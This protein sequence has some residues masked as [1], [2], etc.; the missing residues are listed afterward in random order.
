MSDPTAPERHQRH[1]AH[2]TSQDKRLDELETES[3]VNR[4]WRVG[5]GDVHH[6][7]ESRIY[8]LE[9]ESVL[10]SD[11]DMIAAKV[12]KAYQSTVK[13]QVQTWGPWV[14]GIGLMVYTLVTGQPPKVA[15]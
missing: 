1:E 12:V 2:F 13:A 4:L 8:R 6:G 3:L 5:N 7:A 10:H 15:P 9:E 11:M 14:I